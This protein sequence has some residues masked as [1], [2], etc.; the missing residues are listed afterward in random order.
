MSA[1]S[2]EQPYPIFTDADGD[3]LENGYIW[4]GVENLNPITNPIAVYW[5]AALTQP[6]VQP[7]RT[8]GGYMANAGTPAR[9]Y[10]SGAYSILVQ[11]RNGITAYS[12]Q[13]ES[14]LTSSN[15][16][17]FLQA[18]TGAVTRTAQ[19]KMRDVVS[20]AD[21]GAVGDGTTDD[22]QAIRNALD[23]L[24]A[25]GG[26]LWFPSTASGGVYYLSQGLVINRPVRMMGQVVSANTTSF[27]NGTVL[28]FAASTT[29][30]TFNAYNSSGGEAAYGANYSVMENIAVASVGGSG[31]F[32]GVLIR[33]PGVK[34]KNVWAFGFPRNGI[35]IR[36]QI[37]GGG[38]L[39][40]NANLWTLTDI[41]S[42]LNGSDGL[43]VVG[44][45]SNA[46]CA[47]N[48][49]CS[50]NGGYGIYDSSF[51][52]NTYV[53]C[54]VDNNT[55]GAYKTDNANAQTVFVGCYTEPT[56]GAKS[57]SSLV[58][59][60]V[61]IGGLGSS[62]AN[63]STASTAFVMGGG[64][65]YRRPYV[66]TNSLGA[67]QIGSALGQNDSS[68]SCF[69][70]GTASE[71]ATLDA[72]KLKFDNTSKGWYLQFANS[73][74]YEPITFFNSVS[75]RTAVGTGPLLGNYD[76]GYYVG[77]RTA[78]ILRGFGA[79]APVSGAYVVGD[80]VYNSAPVAGGTIGWVCVT[81]GS[82]GTWKTF[83]AIAA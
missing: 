12:A 22:Y 55:S 28:R 75:A 31:N 24:P 16:V 32:D 83:G 72:W 46:G 51:L 5:D 35:R 7:I 10:T 38:D 27:Y 57:L 2:I 34:L 8:S 69:T 48:V 1:Q 19:A 73:A 39:E 70:W 78:P 60:T 62:E 43:Y 74:F 68:M 17:T 14:V 82:P 79:A 37:G 77:S 41:S 6:A 23:S 67:V 13:S 47:T 40:G 45:D 65:A 33:A 18:G 25:L 80:I 49:N 9:L 15:A 53:G 20:V 36:A 11:D 66:Y 61:F 3:P 76:A 44:N 81:A 63:I 64:G 59:P 21:F 29:G 42:Q 4:I 26:T 71:T 50:N 58:Q 30:V 52:G 54:H 56:Q